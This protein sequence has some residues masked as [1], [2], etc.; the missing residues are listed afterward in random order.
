MFL[1][2]VLDFGFLGAHPPMRNLQNLM[3]ARA[4]KETHASRWFRQYCQE[5]DYGMAEK[6]QILIVRAPRRYGPHDGH[7]DM[8]CT[9]TGGIDRPRY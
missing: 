3:I 6:S 8:R 9:I 4:R 7:I 2:T 5:R 1:S